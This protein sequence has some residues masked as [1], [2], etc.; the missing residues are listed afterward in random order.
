MYTL[1]TPSSLIITRDISGQALDQGHNGGGAYTRKR[2]EKGQRHAQRKRKSQ[3][4]EMHQHAPRYRGEVQQLKWYV[5][6]HCASRHPLLRTPCTHKYILH[7]R[8]RT[9][10]HTLLLYGTVC[11][12]P[13]ALS[14]PTLPC[15]LNRVVEPHR[16]ACRPLLLLLLLLRH[17]PLPSSWLAFSSRPGYPGRA[18]PAVDPCAAPPA[19]SSAPPRVARASKGSRAFSS[20]LA[21]ASF[22][23]PCRDV[24][25]RAKSR[26]FSARYELVSQSRRPDTTCKPAPSLS[27]FQTV[28]VV[29]KSDI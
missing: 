14:S 10:A 17:P 15:L 21:S 28:S 12:R 18:S 3:E 20:R 2:K 6:T 22:Y 27:L 4:R 7:R 8:R 24:Q 23:A 16:A 11:A 9:H 5:I 26:A 19:A 29:F 25:R 13:L 1:I